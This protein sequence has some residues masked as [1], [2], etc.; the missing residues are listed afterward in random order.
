MWIL[1]VASVEF[2][3]P[4]EDGSY[5]CPASENRLVIEPHVQTHRRPIRGRPDLHE[6]AKL[7]GKPQAPAGRIGGV[8]RLAPG[9]RPVDVSRVAD[10][11]HEGLVLAPDSQPA[12]AAGVNH[13]VGGNLIRGQREIAD[14]PLVERRRRRRV[15]DQSADQPQA[16][17]V[18]DRLLRGRGRRRQGCD[19]RPRNR[20]RPRIVTT[21]DA[22]LS[23]PDHRVASARLGDDPGVERARVV[24]TDEPPGRPGVKRKVE[25]RLMPLALD[26]LRRAATDRDRLADPARAAAVSQGSIGEL[27]PGWDDPGGVRAEIGHVGERDPVGVA[28]ERLPQQ[29]DLGRA[30]RDQHRLVGLEAVPNE[31]RHPLNE[32][33]LA[34]IEERLVAKAAPVHVGAVE[35]LGSHRNLS[36][37][38]QWDGRIGLRWGFGPAD[39]QFGVEPQQ[40]GDTAEGA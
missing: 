5:T 28:S 20:V 6:V 24:R 37:A 8:G 38:D 32:L 11:A 2:H 4:R 35:K 17:S 29:V 18:E 16:V 7:V 22:G 39:R 9:E 3:Y 27:A 21:L 25:E 36:L 12:L 13:T 1:L 33:T 30:H 40:V 15:A 10:L 26:Q 34:C 14:T 23:L 31:A 19:E